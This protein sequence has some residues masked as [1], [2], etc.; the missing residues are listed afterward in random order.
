[1]VNQEKY[2]SVIPQESPG[3]IKR[4]GKKSFPGEFRKLLNAEFT[5]EGT[6][7]TRP[8][9]Y[10]CGFFQDTGS[11][12]T[13]TGNPQ[14]GT[15]AT[16]ATRLGKIIGHIR[17]NV[18]FGTYY[19]VS[20]AI[21]GTDPGDGATHQLFCA[22]SHAS[23]LETDTALSTGY[24]FSFKFN[25]NKGSFS[26]GFT[27][28]NINANNRKF[29]AALYY[30]NSNYFMVSMPTAVG[31]LPSGD[32]GATEFGLWMV[33]TTSIPKNGGTLTPAA[34][35]DTGIRVSHDK[36]DTV[37]WTLHRERMWVVTGN[38]VYFSKTG[39]LL[40]WRVPSTVSPDP[41][42]GFFNFPGEDYYDIQGLGDLMYVSGPGQIKAINYSANP[43]TDGSV[44]TVNT[45][46]GGHSITAYGSSIYFVRFDALWSVSGTSVS[47]VKD[48]DLGLV[49]GI[50]TSNLAYLNNSPEGDS[51][52]SVKIYPYRNYL[53]IRVVSPVAISSYSETLTGTTNGSPLA[54]LSYPGSLGQYGTEP[55]DYIRLYP[56]VVGQAYFVN[57][58]NGATHE[59]NHRVGHISDSIDDLGIFCDV[60]SMYVIPG[61]ANYDETL[62][63]NDFYINY[64]LSLIPAGTTNYLDGVGS[65]SVLEASTLLD[66]VYRY[67][68]PQTPST[69]WLYSRPE[70]QIEISNLYP[71]NRKFNTAKW[72]SFGWIGKGPKSGFSLSGPE[73]NGVPDQTKRLNWHWAVTLGTEDSYNLR[74]PVPSVGGDEN[75]VEVIT[76]AFQSTILG[77][78]GTTFDLADDLTRVGL[79][80]RGKSISLCLYTDPT[81]PN[82]V[83]FIDY[84]TYSD[85]TKLDYFND[86][87]RQMYVYL[88]GLYVMFTETKRAGADRRGVSM[89]D[90]H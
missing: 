62:Y 2:V 85:S 53:I 3:L 74:Y 60:S 58:D 28:A 11:G 18:N 37:E 49:E 70:V 72:R 81:Y 40:T 63:F 7:K 6:I 10:F 13:D 42:A 25:S 84:T 87:G 52:L 34:I 1:M 24:G 33:T 16:H 66:A 61:H 88:T 30:N 90:P 86:L 82:S 14:L 15:R 38:S 69:S 35:Y 46:F 47:K 77:S 27:H 67:P 41:D 4:P 59:F 26:S 79:N 57:M 83:E 5:T 36:I 29:I 12:L 19:T 31:T 23:E 9:A 65:D 17:P 48:L 89:N 32:T 44:T 68:F 21:S 76:T 51:A 43:N 39:D 78:I 73:N 22:T 45:Q 20:E 71:G 55:N 56:R 64:N 8:S 80:A 50:N 54:E 75:A